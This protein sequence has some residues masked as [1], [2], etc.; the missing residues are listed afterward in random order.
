MTT[1]PR[2]APPRKPKPLVA[3]P[4]SSLR[5]Y[6]IAILASLYV[7]AF[8]ALGE[9]AEEPVADAELAPAEVVTPLDV[10]P[11]RRTVWWNELPAERRPALTLPPGLRVVEPGT[12]AP[13][14][15]SAA[16]VR[17]ARARPRRLRTRSS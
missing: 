5:L 13:V 1:E 15:A 3:L 7:V 17:V 16:P 12:E 11:E 9:P 10:A 14:V 4:E 6:A 8:L 2:P